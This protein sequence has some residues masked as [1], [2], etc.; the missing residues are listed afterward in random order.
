MLSDVS[1]FADSN[2]DQITFDDQSENL[3]DSFDKKIQKS[4]LE[5]TLDD[6]STKMSNKAKLET[7]VDDQSMVFETA[8]TA[9]AKEVTIDDLNKDMKYL[10]SSSKYPFDQEKY[11]N[12]TIVTYF[13]IF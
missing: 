5:K 3:D 1:P 4:P 8:P 13:Y 2:V 9:P 11:I 10:Q 12:Y 7:N 6:G